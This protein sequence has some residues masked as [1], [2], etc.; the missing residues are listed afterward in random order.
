MLGCKDDD[1]KGA[2]AFLEK[3]F[4]ILDD[5]NILD[6][7]G[8]FQHHLRDFAHHPTI[9]GLVFSLLTKFTGM[10]YGTDKK[11]KG[12]IGESIPDKIFRRTGSSSTVGLGGGTGIPGPIL[13]LLKEISVL[14]F[15][16]DVSVNEDSLSVFLPK[17]FNG[18][19]FAKYD[20][21]GKIIKGTE[22]K[23]DFRGEL[24][25]VAELGRQAIPVIANDCIV[26]TF[27]LSGVLPPN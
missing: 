23:L 13:S 5:G 15:M 18:T 27:S 2:V 9:V 17:L 7:G 8:G 1:I 14:P 24:G 22:I 12:F 26:R 10:S 25:A 4:P 3:K 21:T 20:E 16:K 6:F 19:L 11:S